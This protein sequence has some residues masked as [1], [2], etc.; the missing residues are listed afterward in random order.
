MKYQGGMWYT[1]LTK[2]CFNTCNTSR[3]E[4]LRQT[5]LMTWLISKHS[6]SA[7]PTEPLHR[8]SCTVH[9]SV[10]Y[11]LNILCQHCPHRAPLYGQ[12]ILYCPSLCQLLTKHSV[13]ALPTYSPS[14]RT[15]YLV[16]SISLS[17]I[18]QVCF[19]ANR[20]SKQSVCRPEQ[21]LRVPGGWGSQNSRQLAHEVGK[22]TSLTHRP[23]FTPKKFSWYSFF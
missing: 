23:T 9:L 5:A 18:L 3:H 6:V 4:P 16:L 2:F 1:S 19:T 12:D 8:M 10:S 11:S 22:V 14:I 7:L 20:A 17:V 13:S 15:G 21:A